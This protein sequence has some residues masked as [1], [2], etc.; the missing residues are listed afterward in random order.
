MQDL[1]LT[2]YIILHP[3]DLLLHVQLQKNPQN[4]HLRLSYNNRPQWPYTEY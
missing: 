3:E 4:F 1:K 2:K